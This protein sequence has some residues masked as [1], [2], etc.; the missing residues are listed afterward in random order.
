MGTIPDKVKTSKYYAC[1]CPSRRIGKGGFGLKTDGR[2]WR[3]MAGSDLGVD[4]CGL[5]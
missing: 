3:T 5:K 4:F 1:S 2:I